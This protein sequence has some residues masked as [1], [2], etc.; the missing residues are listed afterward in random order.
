MRSLP[1]FHPAVDSS[2]QSTAVPSMPCRTALI[3][4]R[5]RMIT[6][7]TVCFASLIALPPPSHA[8]IPINARTPLGVYVH[9]DVPDVINLY[10]G[11]SQDQG[12]AQSSPDLHT[13]LRCFYAKLLANPAI[14][15]VIAGLHWDQIELDNPLCALNRSC[16]TSPGGYDWSYADDVFAEANAAHKAVELNITPGTDAPI[17]LLNLIPSCDGLFTGSGTAPLDCGKATFVNFP[18]AK[19]ADGTPPVLP[20][21]WNPLYLLAWDDFLINVNA[22]YHS[23]PA[24][25]SI[26]IAGPMCASNEMIL[27][28]TANG[29]TQASGLP[30]DQ[31]WQKLIHHSFPFRPGYE[32]SDQV[33]IDAGKQAIDAYEAIFSGITI[34]SNPDAADDFPEQPYPFVVHPDNTLYAV[35]CSSATQNPMSCEAKTEILSYFV[36]ARGRNEKS[37]QVGGMTAGTDTNTGDIGVA[38]IKV[39]TSLSPPPDPPI[40]GGA[41]F[42]LEVSS[43][44]TIQQQGCPNWSPMNLNPSDCKNLTPEQAAYNTFTVF[45]DATPDATDFGGLSNIPPVRNAPIQYVAVDFQDLQY[46]QDPA[47]TCQTFLSSMMQGSPSLQDIYNQA[48]YDLLTMAGKP[49]TLPPTTCNLLP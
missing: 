38:G 3:A 20:L 25:V 19:R 18:E 5:S 45:F 27:P 32:N 4:S 33:F 49:A 6:F 23:N 35:D 11:P 13:Y 46:A 17:W 21:P 7:L 12:C 30:A 31:A 29:S 34:V 48:S 10:G 43:K 26:S 16:T 39:L 22:R 42:D 9:V 47:N 24:F 37:T 44:S 28:T 36:T 41:E 8:Q 1:E 15:G 40:I 14:S 2:T